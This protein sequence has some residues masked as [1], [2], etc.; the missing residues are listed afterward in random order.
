MS[1]PYADTLG[2]SM[3]PVT[4]GSERPGTDLDQSMKDFGVR[5]SV[6]RGVQ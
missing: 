3:I 6:H 1:V 4:G 5:M 2:D